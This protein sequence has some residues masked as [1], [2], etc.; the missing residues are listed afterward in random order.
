MRVL[1]YGHITHSLTSHTALR[2]VSVACHVLTAH[3]H[4]SFEVRYLYSDTQEVGG[5]ITI[6]I[7]DRKCDYEYHL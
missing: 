2:R 6:I 7:G 3:A 4:T 1:V 5:A